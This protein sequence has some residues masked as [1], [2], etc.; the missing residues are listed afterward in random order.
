MSNFRL[1]LAKEP[2]KGETD[3]RRSTGKTPEQAPIESPQSES[4]GQASVS[5]HFLRHPIIAVAWA[6]ALS[7][8]VRQGGPKP[9]AHH[10]LAR[11]C[12]SP[13]SAHVESVVAPRAVPLRKPR[14]N[15]SA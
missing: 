2:G 6:V 15:A 12:T 9:K 7:G 1:T 11:P 13:R 3:S 5:R 14:T 4:I 8:D 10:N